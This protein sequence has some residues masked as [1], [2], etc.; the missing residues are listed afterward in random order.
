MGG[1]K[2]GSGGKDYRKN[3]SDLEGKDGWRG[4]GEKLNRK[5]NG[6]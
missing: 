6:P 3:E 1:G 2:Q 4:R 5:G